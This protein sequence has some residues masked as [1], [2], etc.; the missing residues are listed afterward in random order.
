MTES[1]PATIEDMRRFWPERSDADLK[2]AHAAILDAGGAITITDPELA[3]GRPVSSGT[4]TIA[5]EHMAPAGWIAARRLDPHLV[6]GGGH[7]PEAYLAAGADPAD[8]EG[9]AG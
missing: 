4:L 2:A 1:R 5:D 9:L 7:S 6:L 8:V 3:H